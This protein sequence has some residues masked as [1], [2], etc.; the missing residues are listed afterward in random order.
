MSDSPCVALIGLGL[1]GKA[2]ASRL[3]AH[4]YK[5]Y[6]FDINPVARESACVLGVSVVCRTQELV[7]ACPLIM[8]SLPDEKAVRKVL[9][10]RNGLGHI[11]P[12][13]TTILDSTTTSPEA[14]E[15]HA[16]RL[17]ERGIRFVDIP[18]VG[19]SAEIAEGHAVVLAGISEQE[20]D[21][22]EVLKCFAS[23]LFFLNGAGNAHRAKL[24][25]NLVLGANRLVL[26]EAL[27]LAAHCRMD[28]HRVLDILRQS[29]AY[30]RVMDTK[31]PRMCQQEFE[32]P[33]ARLAQH[34]KDVRLILELAKSVGART[35]VSRVHRSVLQEAIRNGLG[36][37]DNSAIVKVFF[38]EKG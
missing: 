35:P 6:G 15:R 20:A 5:V 12:S 17:G 8:L 9:F 19:S 21:F 28:V 26:A 18:L 31:G 13:G 29:P 22:V 1:V 7:E 36:G 33:V 32:P 34:A 37:M 23:K 16:E 4:G 38:G 14:T 24:I 27:G 3:V 10:G 2:V 30:S 25:I 11:C